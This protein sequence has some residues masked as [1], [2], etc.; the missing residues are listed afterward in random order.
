MVK[1]SGK[2]E[3]A[4]KNYENALH[5][6]PPAESGWQPKVLL[7][8]AI[9]NT[10]I[11]KVWSTVLEYITHCKN[12]NYWI[13]NRN[14]QA[15]HRMHETINDS[16]RSNFYQN[17]EFRQRIK[18]LEEMVVSGSISPFLAAKQLLDKYFTH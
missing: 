17:P 4:K 3:L 7:A 12:N 2:A 16:L 9:K 11:D 10:G 5:L 18:E 15:R 14:R 8:S 13:T 1:T 6:F